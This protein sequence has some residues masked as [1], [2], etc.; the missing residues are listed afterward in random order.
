MRLSI[1]I[2]RF[3]LPAAVLALVVPF[4]ASARENGS[5]TP[6]RY[7][8]W[9]KAVDERGDSN[10]I[11]KFNSSEANVG[12]VRFVGTVTEVSASS[13]SVERANSQ[14]DPTIRTF[15]VNAE[16]KVIRKFKSSASINEVVIG[17]RVKVWAS[18][19]TDGTAKLIW[20]KGIWWVALRGT[21]SDVNTTDESFTLTVRRK[22]PETKLTMTMTVPVTTS[23]RTTYWMDSA[24]TSFSDLTNGQTVRIRGTF[25]AVGRYILANR[26]TVL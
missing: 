16:T 21:I 8:S 11:G 17:D 24:S 10:A 22:E 9:M 4:L 13:I 20:D 14:G 23:D 6:I 15:I 3:I 12:F 19:L 7:S 5:S 26:V 25:N 1:T 18:S 2:K